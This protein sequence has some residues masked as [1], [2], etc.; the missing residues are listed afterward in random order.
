M[1][2]EV[3]DKFVQAGRKIILQNRAE[4]RLKGVRAMMAAIGD[5]GKAAA[6]VAHE[7]GGCA[8]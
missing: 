4:N 3:C 6:Y 2:R 5:K 8:R 7:V 1:R